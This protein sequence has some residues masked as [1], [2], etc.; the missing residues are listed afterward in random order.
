[1]ATRINKQYETRGK[2][3]RST[4]Y[5]NNC[6]NIALKKYDR[7]KMAERYQRK[8]VKLYD[9]VDTNMNECEVCEKITITNNSM[10]NKCQD[11][12]NEFIQWVANNLLIK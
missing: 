12:C 3:N 4:T 8:D 1:M 5:H 2:K 11:D 6:V 7:K 9:I 10:C